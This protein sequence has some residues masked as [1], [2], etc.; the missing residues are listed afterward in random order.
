MRSG[1]TSFILK[2]FGLQR[3]DQISINMS[4]VE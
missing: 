2:W 4:K 1:V 3:N